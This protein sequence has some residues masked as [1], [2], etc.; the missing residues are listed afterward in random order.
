LVRATQSRARS[1]C[2]RASFA[3]ADDATATPS[4]WINTPEVDV[5]DHPDISVNLAI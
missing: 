1:Q 3:R 5:A 4:Q 2:S